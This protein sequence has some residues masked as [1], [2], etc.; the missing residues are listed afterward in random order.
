MTDTSRSSGE[1]NSH[2]ADFFG[3][4]FSPV[5][6]AFGFGLAVAGFLTAIDRPRLALLL[7][8]IDVAVVVPWKF[9][10]HQNEL[11]RFAA[12]TSADTAALRTRLEET[13]PR[14]RIQALLK[15]ERRRDREKLDRIR[16]RIA[17]TEERQRADSQT[18]AEFRAK[19]GPRIGDQ[20]NEMSDQR[21]RLEHQARQIEHQAR[22]IEQQAEQL[23]LQK[24]QLDA[25]PKERQRA[26]EWTVSALERTSRRHDA[27]SAQLRQLEESMRLLQRNQ[28]EVTSEL[29]FQLGIGRQY[30]F[31]L[32]TGRS[33]TVSLSRL[34][35]AQASSSVTHEVRPLLP[36]KYDQ[37]LIDERLDYLAQRPTRMVGDVAYYYLPYVRYIA[38][39]LPEARFV[40]MRRNREMVIDSQMRKTQNYNLWADHDGSRWDLNEIWDP[41]MPSYEAMEKEDAIARYWDEYNE[42]TL[43]LSEELGDRFRIFDLEQTFHDAEAVGVLLDHVG[44]AREHQNVVVDIHENALPQA[45][46]A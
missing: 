26:H 46:P 21:K 38:E 3:W 28:S 34:L 29:Q 40:C 35:K 27:T 24:A 37:G 17:R 10:R 9:M 6:L 19:A 33:G 13:L 36:W 20:G 31:G 12:D 42:E 30:V 25:Q 23:R 2:F 32:G 44:I 5:G 16:A 7:L 45:P 39:R 41:T 4:Y 11:R 1:H 43:Q 22:Q 15:T 18:A 8:I 14:R